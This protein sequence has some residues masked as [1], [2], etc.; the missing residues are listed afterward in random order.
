MND[1]GSLLNLKPQ[2]T[3]NQERLKENDQKLK[4]NDQKFKE[5]D[6]RFKE[7]ERKSEEQAEI[8]KRLENNLAELMGNRNNDS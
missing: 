8:I 4:E 6:Q 1:I 5:N 2:F 7:N 3:E